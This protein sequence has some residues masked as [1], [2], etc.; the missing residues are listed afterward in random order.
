MH[1]TLALSIAL[2]ALSAAAQPQRSPLDAL[3]VAQ[4][5]TAYLECD[6]R[7]SSVMLDAGEAANC[8]FVHEALKQRAFGGDFDRLLARWKSEKLAEANKQNRP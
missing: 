1:A 3:T 4:L 2:V 5:K 6:R 7:A 8:S